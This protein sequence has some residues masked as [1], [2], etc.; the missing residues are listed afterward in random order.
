[1]SKFFYK[2]W[3]LFYLLFFL[4]IGWFIYSLLWEPKG[5]MST[6]LVQ[7]QQE[8]AKLQKELD[9][10]RESNLPNDNAD[11]SVL[12]DNMVQSG[13]Q[14]QTTTNHELGNASGVVRI[15]YDMRSIPDEI[16]VFYDNRLVASSNGLTSGVGSLSFNYR[17]QSG[18]P[19]YCTVKMSAPQDGTAWT[20]LLNCPQ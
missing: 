11:G 7:D 4:L 8:L 6:V 16:E 14:G 3:G 19:T 2:N 20:Y 18:K 5:E 1:M 13:G 15:E 17:S 10:C 9:E 12:C